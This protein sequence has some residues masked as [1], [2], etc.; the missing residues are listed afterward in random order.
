MKKKIA[1]VLERVLPFLLTLTITVSVLVCMT[2]SASAA[3]SDLSNNGWYDALDYGTLIDSNGNAV[4]NQF[5]VLNG[6]Y[7]FGVDLPTENTLYAADILLSIDGNGGNVNYD[8]MEIQFVWHDSGAYTNLEIIPIGNNLYRAFGDVP[9]GNYS[10][11]DIRFWNHDGNIYYINV[12]SLNVSIAEITFFKEIGNISLQSNGGSS[13]ASMPNINSSAALVQYWSTSTPYTGTVTFNT[14]RRYDYVDFFLGID[15]DTITS[16]SA[17][18]TYGNILPFSVSY[19]ADSTGS[20]AFMRIRLDLTGMDKTMDVTNVYYPYI[21]ITGEATGEFSL[22]LKSVVGHVV[23]PTPDPDVFWYTKLF[24]TIGSWFSNLGKWLSD[25]FQSV[26]DAIS[27]FVSGS[28]EQQQQVADA[29]DKM[30][31]SSNALGQLG[32]QMNSVEKPAPSDMNVSPNAM[33][34]DTALTAY[35][36]PITYLW[37]NSTLVAMLTIVVTLVLVSWVFFGKKV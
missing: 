21:Q 32:D 12:L 22:S 3:E 4:D 18:D 1:K 10:A 36:T 15:V 13:N 16:V 25:G 29:V 26:V 31:Q 28:P 35:T 6:Y 23:V 11:F 14:W 20:R 9:D 17:S 33:I 8:Q 19:L 37:H 24:N 34:P 7:L 5:F 30:E 2:V 27:N